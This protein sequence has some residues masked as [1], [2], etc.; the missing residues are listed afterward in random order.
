VTPSQIQFGAVEARTKPGRN[1]I[2]VNNRT[3]GTSV[4]VTSARV[5]D[6]AFAAEVSTIEEGRRYQVGVSIK[7]DAEPGS[8]DSVITLT[9]TDPDFPELSVPVRATIR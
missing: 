8:R 1:L 2:V 6:E 5:D 4:E 3:D 7:A 9:T